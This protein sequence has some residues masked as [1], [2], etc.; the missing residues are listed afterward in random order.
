MHPPNSRAD[1]RAG[2]RQKAAACSPDGRVAGRGLRSPGSGQHRPTGRR[3]CGRG[4]STA[5]RPRLRRSNG[6]PLLAR[7]WRRASLTSLMSR[8]KPRARIGRPIGP[9]VPVDTSPRSHFRCPVGLGVADVSGATAGLMGVT[10]DHVAA[11]A[12]MASSRATKMPIRV[13]R[14]MGA[15][16]DF[17]A[18]GAEGWER[19]GRP[20]DP[21]PGRIPDGARRSA[22][23]R[24]LYGPS[25]R[26][27]VKAAAACRASPSSRRTVPSSGMTEAH[28]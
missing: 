16:W 22:W 5:C 1:L 2:P 9:E 10:F 7:T 15:V 14:F 28:Q 23:L 12:T 8:M 26:R 24:P 25:G 3:R 11:I 19:P 27:R 20:F 21:A 18:E 6:A 17:R 13:R 4:S